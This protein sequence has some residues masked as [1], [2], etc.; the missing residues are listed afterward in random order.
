MA[1]LGIIPLFDTPTQYSS[2]WAHNVLDQ[3]EI[4]DL[5]DNKATRQE[6]EKAIQ[7]NNPEFVV[8]SNHGSEDT[9]FAQGGQEGV[10][11]LKNVYLM[12][13]R[14]IYTLAC[15]AGKELLP[16]MVTEG[17]LAA[18]GYYRVYGFYLGEYEP[19]FEEQAFVGLKELL[20]DRTFDEAQKAFIKKSYEMIDELDK[21]GA[22]HVADQIIWNLESL[23]VLGNLDTK[24]P[25]PSQKTPTPPTPSPCN[26][27]NG[28]AKISEKIHNFIPWLL[29]RK[30][31]F[32][33]HYVNP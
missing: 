1:L 31:R 17:A 28:T 24:I 27:G 7:E 21:K 16:K 25:I 9:L 3:Y 20:E 13:G 10:F 2:K 15:L 5:S 29:R 11:D 23:K 6:V 26:V 12:E 4:V 19:Y 32:R 30:G 14:S 8:F 33:I 22:S 18:W